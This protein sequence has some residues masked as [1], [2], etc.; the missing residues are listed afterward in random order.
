MSIIENF[1]DNLRKYRKG[2][3]LTQLELANKIGVSAQTI[4]KYE[5]G[6]A[7]PPAE[8]L[9][10][11]LIELNVTPNSLLLGESEIVFGGI[12][13]VINKE[14][15]FRSRKNLISKIGSE[16]VVKNLFLSKLKIKNSPELPME[17]LE[18]MD[19]ALFEDQVLKRVYVYLDYMVSEIDKNSDE[20]VTQAKQDPTI[21]ELIKLHKMINLKQDEK[22]EN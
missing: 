8:N 18:L 1:S 5:N 15:F 12:E 9:E 19:K 20:V 14:I 11:I 7:F 13:S 6:I 21:R 3:G 22:Y 10:S 4:Y 17:D 16:E 2:I